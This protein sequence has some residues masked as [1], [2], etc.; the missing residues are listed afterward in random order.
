VRKR[1][2]QV[3]KECEGRFSRQDLGI[4]L[5]EHR[6]LSRSGAVDEVAKPQIKKRGIRNA[7][8]ERFR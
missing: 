7:A 8:L 3:G 1:R 4:A 2:K 6:G 5:I